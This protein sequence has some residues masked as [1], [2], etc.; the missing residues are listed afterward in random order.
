MTMKKTYSE[1]IKIPTYEERFRYLKIGGKIGE[2]TFGY[3][4]YLNQV[5]YRCKEWKKTRNEII[6]RDHG[7]DLA[8][9]GYDIYGLIIVHHLNPITVEQI[10]NRD[11]CIFDPENLISVTPR[12]HNA[13][14]YGD[15]SILFTGI[16]QRAKNDTC[17]W[18]PIGEKT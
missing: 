5:L 4:R 2:E 16:K 18:T 1:L 10:L 15:E 13:I 12:T 9:E 7:R 3:D 17:L 11:A 14:H 6:L 8:M